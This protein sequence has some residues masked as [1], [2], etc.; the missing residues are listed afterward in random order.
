MADRTAAEAVLR[1]RFGI[2][3]F[4]PSQ[5]RAVQA[6]LAGHDV[7]VA[8]ATGGGKSICY[9]LVPHV[10]AGMALVISPLLS[11]MQ[12]QVTALR[13]RGLRAG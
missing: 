5:W 3:S 12:D 9:Q 7:V 10:A 4:R 13:A 2:P 11:L 6:A 8:I 1:A